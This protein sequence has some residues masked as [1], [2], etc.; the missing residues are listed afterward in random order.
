MGRI[1]GVNSDYTRQGDGIIEVTPK[2]ANLELKMFICPH[3]QKNALEAESAICTG[4]DSACPNP[5]PK[6]G[7][8]LLHLSESE[9]LR[10]GTDAGTELRLHQN[11]G[12]DAGKIVLSPAASEVRIVGALK[13]EAGG[14][15]V[16]ITPS[17]A[18]I[19]IAG[20]GAEI[21][22]K[23]NGDL[24]LVTQNGTGTVNIM[25]NL[26]VSGTLTRTGQQI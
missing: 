7:H 4:L 6:T 17:A 16:T 11:T 10:L 22:L 26:V 1:N 8:A 20:G 19:S 23:P 9:G 15:T 14:Q 13:L 24:D 18:G 12:P 21:V 2:P 25:G 5:G 3:D